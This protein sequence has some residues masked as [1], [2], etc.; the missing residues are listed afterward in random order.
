MT[1]DSNTKEINLK[2]VA[3]KILEKQPYRIIND[4]KTKKPATEL[5]DFV[6]VLTFSVNRIGENFRHIPFS[7]STNPYGYEKKHIALIGIEGEII[8]TIQCSQYSSM[9]DNDALKKQ[10]KEFKFTSSKDTLV[11]ALKLTE[12]NCKIGTHSYLLFLSKPMTISEMQEKKDAFYKSEDEKRIG[13]DLDA[14]KFIW[15]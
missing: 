3:K 13:K 12:E 14:V 4:S 5:S 9:K 7:L 1:M 10:R 2:E 15:N 11:F 6:D 8:E